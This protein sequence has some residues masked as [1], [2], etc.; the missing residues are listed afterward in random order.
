MPDFLPDALCTLRD[1]VASRQWQAPQA[2]AGYVKLIAGLLAV[3][4]EAADSA[5][6]PDVSRLLVTLF[7]FMQGKELTGIDARRHEII[8]RTFGSAFGDNRSFNFPKTFI[9]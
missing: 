8:T 5:A 3:V 6:D 4:F 2:T 1:R 9:V 7:N